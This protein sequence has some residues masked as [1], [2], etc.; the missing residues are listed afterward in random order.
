MKQATS[1]KHQPSHRPSAIGIYLDRRLIIQSR[2]G[3]LI[4]SLGISGSGEHLLVFLV[5]DEMI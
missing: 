1:N 2:D 3:V 4:P 5:D